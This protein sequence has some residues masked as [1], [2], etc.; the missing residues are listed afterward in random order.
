MSF[1][2]VLSRLEQRGKLFWLPINVVL[3]VGLAAIDIVTG[4]ELG[5]SFFYLL[6]IS[7]MAWF[8]NRR[9][10]VATSVVCALV[11]HHAEIVVG[12]VYSEPFYMY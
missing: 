7:L 12:H 10:A 1:T 3:T 9:F 11:W 2:D 5:F 4:Y 8:V 6:P